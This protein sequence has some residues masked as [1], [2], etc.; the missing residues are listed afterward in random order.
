[1]ARQY[2]DARHRAACEAMRT[3]SDLRSQLLAAVHRH[4]A[5]EG[6]EIEVSRLAMHARLRELVDCE[7]RMHAARKATTPT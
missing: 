3:R 4:G 2:K 6:A 5:A 1:M 7:R